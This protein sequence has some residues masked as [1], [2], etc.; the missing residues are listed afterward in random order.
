M[1]REPGRHTQED[2]SRATRA[3]LIATARRLFTERG[4]ADVSSAEIVTAAGL[5]RG[6]L[7]HHYSDKRDLFRAV[8]VELEAE[9]AAELRAAAAR[10]GDDPAMGMLAALDTF[11]S[12]C[13]RDE[14]VRIGLTDAPAVLGWQA[15]REIET[16][17][18][19]GLLNDML[20]HAMA[21]GLLPRM[22]VR[23]LAQLM[24]STV[25]EAALLVANAASGEERAAVRVQVR[26]ALLVMLPG[27][28]PPG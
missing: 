3:A 26:Q 10:A 13:E 8:F 16:E 7:Y 20:E 2:R 4:Y 6:A 18:G 12:A 19:L 17:H 5:S 25:I 9:L 15:W 28:T 11:L 1:R 22:P 14:M 24:L 27:L 21:A 23:V